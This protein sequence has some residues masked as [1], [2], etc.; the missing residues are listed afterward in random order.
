MRQ[1]GFVAVIGKAG[2]GFGGGLQGHSGVLGF[3]VGNAQAQGF[4]G[5]L[6]IGAGLGVVQCG[7]ELD[8]AGAYGVEAGAGAA[9][10]VF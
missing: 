4:D 1:A 10:D 7:I 8:Q 6:G 3:E 2:Q 5:Q 9:G